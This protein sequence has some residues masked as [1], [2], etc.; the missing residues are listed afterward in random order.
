MESFLDKK[1]WPVRPKKYTAALLPITN[2][3]GTQCLLY[4]RA[5]ATSC[6][7][8]CHGNQDSL[9]NIHSSQ[10]MYHLANQCKCNVLVPEY[11]NK[12]VSGAQYDNK[13]IAAFESAYNYLQSQFMSHKIYAIGHSMGVALALH[14]CKNHPPDSMLLVNGF[15]SIRAFVPYF[16]SWIVPDRL[17]NVNVIRTHYAQA[18]NKCNLF[19]L[20]GGHDEEIPAFHSHLLYNASN[21]SHSKIQCIQ[22][23]QHAVDSKNLIQAFQNLQQQQQH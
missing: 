18:K 21:H 8:Y 12:D 19:I 17:N 6:V 1:L 4:T 11:P 13:V 2:A 16:L 22:K 9:Q 15:A 20:H 5:D 7:L 10:V 3:N 14:A 23:M